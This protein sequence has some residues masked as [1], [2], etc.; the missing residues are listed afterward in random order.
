MALYKSK[1][2]FQKWFEIYKNATNEVD[3]NKMRIKCNLILKRGGDVYD[4][5]IVVQS[6]VKLFSHSGT[7]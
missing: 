6:S 4:L 1:F 2:H 7:A 3:S 5:H